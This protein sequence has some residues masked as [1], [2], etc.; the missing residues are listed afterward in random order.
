MNMSWL[1][2]TGLALAVPLLW[3][4]AGRSGW[5]RRQDEAAAPPAVPAAPVAPAAPPVADAPDAARQA[6]AQ[7]AAER[8]PQGLA[9]QRAALDAARQ[10]AA[11]RQAQIDEQRRLADAQAAERR[12]AEQR[13]A[14]Q[15]AAD[16]AA[17]Y[18]ARLQAELQAELQAQALRDAAERRARAEAERQAA[19]Q[20]ALDEQQA[21][22][23]AEPPAA[24]PA[25][26]PAEPP[27]VLVVDDSKVVRVKVSRLLAQHQY[28]VALAEDGE[29]A[30]RQLAQQPPQLV[31]TDVEMPGL[32]GFGLT[33][34]LRAEAATARLPVI[35]IT[36]ADDRHRDEAAAAGVDVLLGKPYGDDE[37]LARIAQVL[38]GTPQAVAS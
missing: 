34:R 28:R 37:L 2:W 36:S 21:A 24:E 8:A 27:L 35:M 20:R 15:R 23:R 38:R 29:D 10:Q 12:A 7:A 19:L 30:L 22:R 6:A 13:A 17:A 5:R 32:D 16:E 1:W 18:Q 33:R 31:I 4:L 11:Q 9:A 3:L 26:A 25:V 14:E